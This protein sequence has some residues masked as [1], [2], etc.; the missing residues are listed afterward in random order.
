METGKEVG[1]YEEILETNTWLKELIALVK[2][3]PSVEAKQVRAIALLLTRGVS[4]WLK[5]QDKHSTI[6]TSLSRV[7][8]KLI[9]DFEQWKV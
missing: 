1:R 8:N 4:S 3:E 5:V 7:T 2:G 9:E 6:F